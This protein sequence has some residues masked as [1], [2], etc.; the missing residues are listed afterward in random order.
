MPEPPGLQ[1]YSSCK[2]REKAPKEVLGEQ[3]RKGSTAL[4]KRRGQGDPSRPA[5]PDYQEERAKIPDT[6]QE[7]REATPPTSP[8]VKGPQETRITKF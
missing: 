4:R 1:N 7:F 2:G 5:P 6:G 3:T 8:K